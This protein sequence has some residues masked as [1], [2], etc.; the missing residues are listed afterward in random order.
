[1]KFEDA[2]DENVFAGKL[3]WASPKVRLKII[4]Q[5]FL[6]VEQE[7][8]VFLSLEQFSLLKSDKR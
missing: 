6:R 3:I 7:A 1:M 5:I 2:T 4:L 8:L